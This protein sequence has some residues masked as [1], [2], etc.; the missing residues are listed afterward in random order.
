MTA[1]QLKK[2]RQTYNKKLIEADSFFKEF[3]TLDEK[4]YA[5]GAISKKNKELM[6]LAISVATRCNEC[7]LLS[8]GNFDER[9]S[10]F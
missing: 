1:E 6:G 3:S 9:R 2:Q 8:S 5:E 7:I 10:H 4:A